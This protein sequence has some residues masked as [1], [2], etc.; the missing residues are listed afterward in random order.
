LDLQRTQH[1]TVFAFAR[2]VGYYDRL[3]VLK[4]GSR[5]LN[6]EISETLAF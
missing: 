6:S 4:S 3:V 1:A 2:D 5:N